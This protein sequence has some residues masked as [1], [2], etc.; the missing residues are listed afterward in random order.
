MVWV[1]IEQWKLNVIYIFFV[2][3][4]V[5]HLSPPSN[6]GDAAMSKENNNLILSITIISSSI[7]NEETSGERG[8]VCEY[9]VLKY[10]YI[11]IQFTVFFFPLILFIPVSYC[12]VCRIHLGQW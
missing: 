1:A 5:F 6:L 9:Y 4:D 2:L 8:S 10:E 7:M 3:R 12:L 11:V